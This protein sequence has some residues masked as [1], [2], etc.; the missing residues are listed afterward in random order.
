MNEIFRF[1][2]KF[3]KQLEKSQFLSKSSKM[4]ILD[5]IFKKNLDFD[6]IFE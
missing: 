6:K 4:S 5:K 1:Y 3:S 2:M